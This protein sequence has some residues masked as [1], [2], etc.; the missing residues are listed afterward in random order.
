MRTGFR[1]YLQDNSH[2]V[3]LCADFELTATPHTLRARA[4]Y[5]VFL[6]SPWGKEDRFKSRMHCNL[7]RYAH[8]DPEWQNYKTFYGHLAQISSKHF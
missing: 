4:S 1:Y 5:V 2:V 8:H 7:Y 6:P 3:K